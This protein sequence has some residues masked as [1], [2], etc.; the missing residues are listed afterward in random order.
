MARKQSLPL[1]LAH[2]CCIIRLACAVIL[3]LVL[4]YSLSIDF[5]RFGFHLLPLKLS[6]LT[7]SALTVSALTVSA[8]TVACT[9]RKTFT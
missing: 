8:L 4:V 1:A 7:V 6:A 9:T 2:A 5:A 3:S